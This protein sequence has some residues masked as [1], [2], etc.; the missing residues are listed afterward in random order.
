[1][2]VRLMP[3]PGCVN[4][5][6][7]YGNKTIISSHYSKTQ[8]GIQNTHTQTHTDRGDEGCVCVIEIRHAHCQAKHNLSLFVELPTQSGFPLSLSLSLC[9]SLSL[10]LAPLQWQTVSPDE[11]SSLLRTNEPT[12]MWMDVMD[13][14]STEGHSRE[15]PSKI[16]VFTKEI[17]CQYWITD[18]ITK[19]SEFSKIVVTHSFYM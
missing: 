11:I 7:H 13:E 5:S 18:D 17:W 19:Y 2:R 16:C 10:F 12:V 1:M 15:S 4:A 8:D 3:L 9:L 14:C 6:L